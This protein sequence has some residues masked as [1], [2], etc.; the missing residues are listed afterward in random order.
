MK[1]KNYLYVCLL[2]LLLLISGCNNGGSDT[3][4]VTSAKGVEVHKT[5]SMNGN[6]IGK[7][8]HLE[9]VDVISID[10]RWAKINYQGREAYVTKRH[11]GKG[12][13][14]YGVWLILIVL[15]FGGIYLWS[16]RSN[17][18]KRFNFKLNLHTN[19]VQ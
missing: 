17:L 18:A 9:D 5:P 14:N 7:L 15:V 1:L 3:Y 10:G 2:P 8:Q 6:V 11:I 16:N 12:H 13:G 4:H 19:H